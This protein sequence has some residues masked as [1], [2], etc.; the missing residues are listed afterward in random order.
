M[1]VT[2]TSPKVNNTFTQSFQMQITRQPDS[3]VLYNFMSPQ[4]GAG[5][6]DKRF[7]SKS[8]TL[9]FRAYISEMSIA[10]LIF[11]TETMN[12]VLP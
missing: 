10:G 8:S 3:G 6:A 1:S 11:A 4:A 2:A 12:Y 7:V 5:A 9:A